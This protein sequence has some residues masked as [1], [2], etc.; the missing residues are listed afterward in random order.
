MDGACGEWLRGGNGASWEPA[1]LRADGQPRVEVARRRCGVTGVDP[2]SLQVHLYG[3]GQE[4]PRASG[5][6]SDPTTTLRDESDRPLEDRATPARGVRNR[7][8][9]AFERGDAPLDARR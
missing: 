5:C 3:R 4:N 9:I 1:S 8:E 7:R 2:V 6:V